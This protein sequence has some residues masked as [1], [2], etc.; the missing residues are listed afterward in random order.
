[1]PEKTPL[2]F[3]TVEPAGWCDP[4]TGLCVTPVDED[5]SEPEPEPAAEGRHGG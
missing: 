4:S 3:V 2:E 1:M 5:T